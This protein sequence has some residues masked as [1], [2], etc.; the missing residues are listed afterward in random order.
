MRNS[1]RERNSSKDVVPGPGGIHIRPESLQALA[2]RD[3]GMVQSQRPPLRDRLWWRAVKWLFV[4]AVFCATGLTGY[5]LYVRYQIDESTTQLAT[6]DE[7]IADP[8]DDRG[9]SG[10]PDSS[11]PGTPLEASPLLLGRAPDAE[12][13]RGVLDV[14]QLRDRSPIESTNVHFEVHTVLAGTNGWYTAS[15]GGSSF[16]VAKLGVWYGA[17]LDARTEQLMFPLAASTPFALRELFVPALRPYI[18]LHEQGTSTDIGVEVTEYLLMFDYAAI[19]SDAAAQLAYRSL[20]QLTGVVE[21]ERWEIGVDRDGVVRKL[22]LTTPVDD[23]TQT[24]TRVRI[25]LI[26]FGSTPVEFPTAFDPQPLPADVEL[27]FLEDVSG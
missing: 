12:T 18:V 19:A 9:P 6:T 24:A 7:I 3:L 27:P 5:W 10:V 11:G 8:V 20:H 1:V 13:A 2:A 21:I 14:V 15:V 22:T 17:P 4:V 26:T 23:A 16:T 25:Q